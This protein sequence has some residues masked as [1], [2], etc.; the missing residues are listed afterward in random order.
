MDILELEK[1]GYMEFYGIPVSEIIL[2]IKGKHKI[3]VN[4]L[5]P[6][7]PLGSY[8][9][10]LSKEFGMDKFP[11]HTDGAN[12]LIP[13]H[14]TI[15]EYAGKE[16]SKCAT[17]LVDI[18]ELNKI[19]NHDDIFHNEIYLVRGSPHGI[20]T[21]LINKQIM[22]ESIFR[23]NGLIMKKLIDKTKDT[24]EKNIGEPSFRINWQPHKTVII[25]NWRTLHSRESVP[26]DEEKSRIINRYNLTP[27]YG[28]I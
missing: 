15:L 16:K 6:N 7:K 26:L 12:R 21:P 14:W 9:T 10:T 22:K 28:R 5:V 25:D 3:E 17:L 1:Q 27:I 11:F 23:W 13:P 19:K 18:K 20:I 4:Q 8:R 2:K 24:F